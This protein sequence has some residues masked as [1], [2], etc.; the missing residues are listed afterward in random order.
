MDLY[1]GQRLSKITFR[2]LNWVKEWLVATV[3]KPLFFRNGKKQHQFRQLKE[4]ES[5]FNIGTPNQNKVRKQMLEQETLGEMG[6]TYIFQTQRHSKMQSNAVKS[7]QSQLPL[8]LSSQVLCIVFIW[9]ISITSSFL[10]SYL[11]CLLY[12]LQRNTRV[13]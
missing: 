11:I 12:V 8:F 7:P 5:A 1:G 13:R 10:V 9:T 2:L 3:H 6:C 4:I